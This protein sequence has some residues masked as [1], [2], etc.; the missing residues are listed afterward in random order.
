[1]SDFIDKIRDVGDAIIIATVAHGDQTDRQ[2]VPYIFHPLRVA[3]LAID[4]G[5]P[6]SAVI[7]A[8]LHDTVEDTEMT[9]DMLTHLAG[10]EVGGIVDL[11]SR[12]EGQTYDQFITRIVQDSRFG[13]LAAAVK[14]CDIAD[15]TR[16][17][18]RF[19]GDESLRARYATAAQRLT[20][21]AA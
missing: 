9:L 16:D 13:P 8:V 15:N 10:E 6:E 20:E 14:Q 19:P 2:G 3:N 1:M 17:D 4:R 7:A 11:L 21:V 12:R 5:L 18:R